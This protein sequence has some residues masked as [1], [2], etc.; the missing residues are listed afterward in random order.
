MAKLMV[1]AL[2]W[3]FDVDD[4]LVLRYVHHTVT[5]PFIKF[6]VNI[7]RIE[8]GDLRRLFFLLQDLFGLCRYFLVEFGKDSSA[9]SAQFARMSSRLFA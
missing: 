3:G 6:I 5:S 9:A 7:I 4:F 8:S 1:F 2:C